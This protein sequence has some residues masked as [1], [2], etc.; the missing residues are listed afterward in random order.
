MDDH[1]EF[2]VNF[3]K[4]NASVDAYVCVPADELSS[5]FDNDGLTEDDSL[6]II[7]WAQ[8]MLLSYH[9]LHIYPANWDWEIEGI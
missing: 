2:K 8:D 1:Y 5:D 4:G 9:N 3:A 7:H 6:T